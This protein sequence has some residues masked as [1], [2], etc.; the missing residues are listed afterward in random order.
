MTFVTE[1]DEAELDSAA[2]MAEGAR[3][4][5]RRVL[6]RIRQRRFKAKRKDALLMR[7]KLK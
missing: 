7:E 4:L 5:R 2:H 1:K 3:A 6:A